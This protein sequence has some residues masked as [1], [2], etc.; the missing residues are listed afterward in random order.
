MTRRTHLLDREEPHA[1]VELHP[2]DADRL[3]VRDHDEVMV[4]SR[5]GEVRVMARVTEM[6]LPGVIFMPFHFAEGAVNA[7]T[8]NVLDPESSIPEFK[9]C[10]ALV[11][12]V[13]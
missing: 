6:V 8:N 10:A 1:F 13:S 12:R 2:S 3:G 4:A 5:R 9:V 7:L 11:R